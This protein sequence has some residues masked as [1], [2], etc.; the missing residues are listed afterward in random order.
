[1]PA[2]KIEDGGL[3]IDK[4]VAGVFNLRYAILDLRSSILLL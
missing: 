1:V 3:R 4:T 2:L